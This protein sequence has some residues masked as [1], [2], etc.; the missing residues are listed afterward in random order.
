MF[1]LLQIQIYSMIRDYFLLKVAQHSRNLM[2]LNVLK[3]FVF[4]LVLYLDQLNVHFHLLLYS[5]RNLC[6]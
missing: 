3:P 2:Y 4:F 5:N 1:V 6:L